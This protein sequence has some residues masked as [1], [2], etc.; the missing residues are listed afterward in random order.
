MYGIN[1]Y[2]SNSYTTYFCKMFLLNVQFQ[3]KFLCFCLSG[4]YGNKLD[5]NVPP[6]SSTTQPTNAVFDGCFYYFLP[7]GDTKPCVV[8]DSHWEDIGFRLETVNFLSHIIERLVR[9]TQDL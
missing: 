2:L 7:W 6:C 4:N 9:L 5:D 3:Y 8:I 1:H